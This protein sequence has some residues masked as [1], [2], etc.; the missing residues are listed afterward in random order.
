MPESIRDGRGKGYLAE[1][2]SDNRLKISSVSRSKEHNANIEFGDAYIMYFEV[3][4]TN[5]DSVFL[6]MQ[7]NSDKD[8]VVEGG[9][10]NC[11]TA[12][13]LTGKFNPIGTRSGGSTLTPANLNAGSNNVADG[14][15]EAGGDITGLSNGI[16]IGT[17]WFPGV[18]ASAAWNFEADLVIPKNKILIMEGSVAGAIIKGHLLFWHEHEGA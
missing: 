7:N 11:D 15:F 5:N 12:C 18:A 16:G 13:G 6:Y 3:T 2:T 8:I 4:V 1:V 9:A 10:I 14:T 17:L